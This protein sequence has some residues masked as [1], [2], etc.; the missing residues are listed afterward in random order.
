MAY[1]TVAS[2]SGFGAQRQQRGEDRKLDV[3]LETVKTNWNVHKLKPMSK[4]Q[5]SKLS[6]AGQL[7]DEPVSLSPEQ[8]TPRPRTPLGSLPTPAR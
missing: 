3:K 5:V 7:Q 1:H 4:P 2:V 8:Y 6:G